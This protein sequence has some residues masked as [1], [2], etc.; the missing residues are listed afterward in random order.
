MGVPQGD[1]SP[2][3]LFVT[4]PQ[5]THTAAPVAHKPRE[6]PRCSLQLES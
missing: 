6:L 3:P 1:Q 2:A 4:P 5:H